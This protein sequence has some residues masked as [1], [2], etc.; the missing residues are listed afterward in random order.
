MICQVLLNLTFT[1]SALVSKFQLKYGLWI[2][3]DTCWIAAFILLL[4]DSPQGDIT[5]FIFFSIMHGNIQTLAV[6]D[7]VRLVGPTEAYHWCSHKSLDLVYLTT[8]ADMCQ[9]ANCSLTGLALLN[10]PPGE[11]NKVP[12]LLCQL[13]KLAREW[14]SELQIGKNLQPQTHHDLI[15]MNCSLGSQV[16]TSSGLKTC[17]P[18]MP[19]ILGGAPLC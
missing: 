14:A 13:Q 12:E 4:P 7:Q 10:L 6:P 9:V 15:T 5:C 19:T 17:Q 3:D 16:R 2:P 11:P 18:Y 1:I 8:S